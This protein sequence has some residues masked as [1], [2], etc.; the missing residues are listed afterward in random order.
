M[1]AP[2]QAQLTWAVRTLAEWRI[3]LD[4]INFCRRLPGLLAVRHLGASSGVLADWWDGP[5]MRIAVRNLFGI[6]ESADELAQTSQRHFLNPF[7]GEYLK[8]TWPTGTINTRIRAGQYVDWLAVEKDGEKT[9]CKLQ[10][11]CMSSVRSK[12]GELLI[13]AVPLGVFLMRQPSAFSIDEEQLT[14]PRAFAEA[15]RGL[16]RMD[17][18]EFDQLFDA[19]IVG[20]PG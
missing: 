14:G 13:P 4:E 18:A 8:K 11:T 9:R 10:P 3:D 17:Q 20:F 2:N 12:L 16:L 19:S 6:A 15:V 1:P 5:T 7:S